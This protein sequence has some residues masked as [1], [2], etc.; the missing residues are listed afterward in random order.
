MDWSLLVCAVKRHVTYAPTEPGFREQLSQETSTGLQWRCLRCGLLVGG[1]PLGAGPAEDAP[2]IMRGRQLRDAL[3]LRFLATER[4]LRGLLILALAYGV[5]RF[6]SSQA[7]LSRVFEQDLPLLKPLADKLG[8]NLEQSGV[9]TVLRTALEARHSTLVLLTFG[10][11]AYG[12]IQVVEA[13][14]LWLLRRWGEYFAVISTS[15]F[16]PL[17][18]YELIERVTVTRVLALTIN[19]AAVIYLLLS[20]RLFGLRG[21]KRAYDAERHSESLIEVETVAEGRRYRGERQPT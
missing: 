5:Y 16:L 9:V 1:P 15:I 21:G 2:L 10:L 3:I 17:E 6:S 13:I 11:V 18:I 12:L 7:T 8:Y 20:K 14:G 4:G 19:V